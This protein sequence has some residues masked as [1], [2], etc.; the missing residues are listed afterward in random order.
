[1]IVALASVVAVL[2]FAAIHRFAGSWRAGSWNGEKGARRG[3]PFPSLPAV[4]DVLDEVPEVASFAAF[5]DP[6][7]RAIR[8]I[9]PKLL[10]DC[11]PTVHSRPLASRHRLLLMRISEPRP[12]FAIRTPVLRYSA[13]GPER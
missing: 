9:S 13:S 3:A 11:L 8:G 10:E 1:V 6:G 7:E 5:P 2:A 12:N 4:E